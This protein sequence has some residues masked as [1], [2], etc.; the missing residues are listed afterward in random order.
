MN[1]HTLVDL[2]IQ[3]KQVA[4]VAIAQIQCWALTLFAYFYIIK[5][6]KDI[7][8]ANVDA[9]SQLPLN[10][11]LADPQVPADAVLMIQ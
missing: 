9:C 11:K 1:R 4:I 3:N 7:I 5:Y 10:A 2:L 8:H 6:H